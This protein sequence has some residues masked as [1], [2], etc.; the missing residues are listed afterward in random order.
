MIGGKRSLL[1]NDP[2][3][4]VE[5]PAAAFS[6]LPFVIEQK[7]GIFRP[8]RFDL[9]SYAGI[10]VAKTYYVDRES[11]NDGN[12]GADWGNALATLNA[13]W[14][15]ADVDRVYVRDSVFYYSEVKDEPTRNVETIGVGT[16]MITSDQGDTA[17]AWSLVD[18]HYE[19][20]MGTNTYVGS[21][22]DYSW[23][24][25]YGLPRPLTERASIAE[26]DANAG[27]F[28]FVYTPPNSNIYIRTYDD[29]EPDDDLFYPAAGPFSRT[30]DSQ[31]LY[32]E[33]LEFR[34]G[35]TIRN[36]SAAGGMKAY[37]KNCQFETMTIAGADV[38][39]QDCLGQKGEYRSGDMVNIDVRNGVLSHVVEID[40]I[41]RYNDAGGTSDQSST[42]HNGCIIVRI[43]GEYYQISGQVVADVG[44]CYSW[45]LGCVLRD[46]VREEVGFYTSGDAWLDRCEISGCDTYDLENAGAGRLYYRN[47]ISAG[48][49]SGDCQPY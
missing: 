49:F 38:I 17:G 21:V 14:G 35:M 30:A 6:W 47:L 39:L 15:K 33:N 23:P 4:V 10:S 44:G 11:G 29:R 8:K 26:V 48:N 9:Q 34:P 22:R 40:C 18:S 1:L 24:D 5:Q 43:G 36:N 37:L 25:A 45:L 19:T 7:G 3:R 41:M 28:Y 42:G 32:F 16:V 12:T 20:V 46:S 2:W 27:S 13:A 31:T